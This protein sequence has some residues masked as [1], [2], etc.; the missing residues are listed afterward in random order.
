MKYALLS[1][2]D[3][4]GI[5]DLAHAL[6]R[7]DYTIIS[8]GGTAKL[9]QEH[10]FAVVPVE[11]I[12]HFPEC[13][14]GR[15]KTIHPLIAGGLLGVRSNDAHK[16]TMTE[17]H[18][19]DIDVLAVN[20]YPFKETIS[21]PHTPDE[22]IENIDIGGPGM[23]RAA[24]KN[25]K[26]V[27]VLTNTNDYVDFIKKL[28][29]NEIDENYRFMLAVKAFKHTASYDA[30]IANYLSKDAFPETLTLVYEKNSVLRYGE[31]P[32]QAAAYYAPADAQSCTGIETL[33]ILHGKALSY[34]NIT[35]AQ[36][37]IALVGEF[38]DDA[39]CVAVKHGTPC[40]VA[41]REQ[42]CDA[43]VAAHD[44]DPQSIFGG[45]VAFNT[46]IDAETATKMSEI[47]LE[48][49]IAPSF[50]QAALDILTKK[51]NIRLLEMPERYHSRY[52]IRSI[53]GGL[54]VQET[55]ANDI[56]TESHHVVTTKTPTDAELKDMIFAMKI[57]KHVKS[58]AI[59]VVKSGTLLGQGGGEVSRIWAAEHAIMRAGAHAT[60]AVLASDALLPFSDVVNACAKAG[61]TAIIQPGGSVND[62]QSIDAANQNGIGMVFTGVRHFKH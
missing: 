40:G 20:L 62:A 12:T 5:V 37:A 9:L 21:R 32:H 38:N 2:S 42:V 30:M 50:S 41:V 46:E 10:G 54:L 17:H 45:I 14:D 6:T 31:N 7:H 55:D 53:S 11:T 51:K 33:N 36:A 49:I 13:M 16:A 23:I 52:E 3:K 27:S 59:V 58:N 4:L 1:V 47:F 61:I 25:H 8:T 22:A 28:D 24:A 56:E 44:C 18:I 19:P 35:D 26:F 39:V 15:L 48:V 29:A 43:Y 34:N 60:G 57:V